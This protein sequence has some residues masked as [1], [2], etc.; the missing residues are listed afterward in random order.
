M[1]FKV[2]L[3]TIETIILNWNQ[4]NDGTLHESIIQIHDV[5]LVNTKLQ[6]PRRMDLL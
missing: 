4:S 1:A 2:N 5:E 6:I 3:F